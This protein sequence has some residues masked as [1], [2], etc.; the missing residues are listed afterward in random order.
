M[1]FLFFYSE[2]GLGENLNGREAMRKQ[3]FAFENEESRATAESRE[4]R[5][6]HHLIRK[7]PHS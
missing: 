7:T 1:D 3:R 6:V 5:S 2:L 4:P